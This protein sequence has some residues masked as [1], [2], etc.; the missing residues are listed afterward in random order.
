MTFFLVLCLPVL[1]SIVRLW[2]YLHLVPKF[3]PINVRSHS[4]LFLFLGKSSGY[5]FLFYLLS[6]NNFELQ[7]K[8]FSF[9]MDRDYN[10][11]WCE[12]L[13]WINIILHF[14]S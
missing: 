8:I 11:F 1:L 5:S 12:V 13:L 4:L 2:N 10:N 6:A 3:P 14:T 9:F 7:V